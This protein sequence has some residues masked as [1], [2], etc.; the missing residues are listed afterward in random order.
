MRGVQ[1]NGTRSRFPI[2][3][4]GCCRC[5]QVTTLAGE[6]LDFARIM[7]VGPSGKSGSNEQ[8]QDDLGMYIS[9]S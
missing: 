4:Y 9:I 6:G 8:K 1:L 2:K 5:T 7:A 3:E